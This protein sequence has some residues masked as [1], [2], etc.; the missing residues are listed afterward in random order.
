MV[1]ITTGIPNAYHNR[2]VQID[3]TQSGGPF[4]AL[5]QLQWQALLV[6]IDRLGYKAA[7]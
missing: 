3:W 4:I 2:T 7:R 6:E 5:T 1:T